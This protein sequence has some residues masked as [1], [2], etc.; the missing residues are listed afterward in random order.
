ME[1]KW[2]F[3]VSKLKESIPIASFPATTEKW[4][5]FFQY[6]NMGNTSVHNLHDENPVHLSELWLHHNTRI[7]KS[8]G[9]LILG[10]LLYY[11]L[12]RAGISLLVALVG[13]DEPD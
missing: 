9:L 3:Q 12:H 7:T 6:L 10:L 13:I 8:I 11:L 4:W 5:H 2:I 1:A